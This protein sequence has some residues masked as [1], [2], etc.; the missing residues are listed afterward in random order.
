MNKTPNEIFQEY[1]NEKIE[2]REMPVET[3][4]ALHPEHKE[5]LLKKIA[6]LEILPSPDNSRTDFSGKI[7]DD[8]RIIE[9]VGHGGMGTAYLAE[10][11]SLKRRVALKVLSR[12][13][14]AD[15]RVVDRFRR[16]GQLI[17]KLDHRG[18]VPVYLVGEREDMFYIA[19]QYVEGISLY[20]MIQYA[21]GM[22][23]KTLEPGDVTDLIATELSIEDADGITIP[24]GANWVEMSCNM[25]AK[26]AEAVEYAHRHGILHRDIKPSNIILTKGGEPVLLDFGLGKDLGAVDITTS[27]EMFGTPAYSAPEQLFTKNPSPDVRSDV[28]SLGMTL[29]ELIAFNLPYDGETFAD[30]MISIKSNEPVPPTK[31]NSAIPDGLCAIIVKAIDKD[32]SQ[33]YQTACDFLSDLKQ[34]AAGRPVSIKSPAARG[35]TKYF[36]I[37]GAA[38]IAAVSIFIYYFNNISPKGNLSDYLDAVGKANQKFATYAAAQRANIS[39]DVESSIALMMKLYGEKYSSFLNIHPKGENLESIH[40]H[41]LTALS[42]AYDS[43]DCLLKGIGDGSIRMPK[44]DG[45]FSEDD[46]AKTESK[47][48]KCY[49]ANIKQYKDRYA[50]YRNMLAPLAAENGL[51]DEYA[52]AF[53]KGAEVEDIVK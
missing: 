29:Y 52:R 34:F 21:R 42:R 30:L 24:S 43:Y 39:G 12:S 1:L 17:A 53:P 5:F 13:L 16:E 48:M 27:R 31:Y 4:I 26:V 38:L 32:A 20:K 33:R 2:G 41:L 19:M 25:I 8:F 10:Q 14:F 7:I 35:R 23:K 22:G 3:L 47:F 37:A 44:G 6:A 11:I 50:A 28:Y 18:I 36:Y 46:F 9:E 40:G 51:Q 15:K 45:D 49:F